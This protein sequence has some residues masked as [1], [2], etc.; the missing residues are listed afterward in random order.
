MYT[1]S[2]KACTV[3]PDV[4]HELARCHAIILCIYIHIKMYFGHMQHAIFHVTNASL[5]LVADT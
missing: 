5:Y 3:P 4:Y 2:Y 1:T